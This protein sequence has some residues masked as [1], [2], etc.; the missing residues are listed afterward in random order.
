MK[1]LRFWLI[2]IVGWFFILFNIERISAPINLAS[3]VYVYTAL[4]SLVML[5]LFPYFQLSFRWAFPAALIPYFL[6]KAQIGHPIGGPNLP[7][8]VTEVCALGITILF[9][10]QIV[11]LLNELRRTVSDLSL[12]H[13]SKGISVF[14]SG[15]ELIYREIRRARLHNRPAA[16]LSISA[17]EASV[18]VSLSRF[19]QEAQQEIIQ[20]YVRA[21]I[22]NLLVSKL[23]DHDVV[24]QRDDHFIVLLSEIERSKVNIVTSRLRN[25]AKKH[26]GLDLEIGISTFPDEALTLESLIENAEARM[27]DVEAEAVSV[28]PVA[29][30]ESAMEEK[31]EAL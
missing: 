26:L 7:I 23:K 29:S 19:I 10:E 22:A 8:T 28:Q 14:D 24:T 1:R 27:A 20:H 11:G 5:A 17:T 2:V 15:Q 13:L 31:Q 21:R 30:I 9:T 6:V 12:R 4:I 16:L 3:F 25:A 18:D